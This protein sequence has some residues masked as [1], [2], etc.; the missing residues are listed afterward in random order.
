MGISLI[1]TIEARPASVTSTIDSDSDSREKPG[2]IGGFLRKMIGSK[3]RS[4]AQDLPAAKTSSPDV[5]EKS[6]TPAPHAQGADHA[7]TTITEPATVPTFRALSFKF[8]LEMQPHNKAIPPMR[9]AA[10]RLPTPAQNYLLATSTK[11]STNFATRAIEPTGES[12]ARAR[13]AGRA[14]AEW[15]IVV[16]ECGSFFDRRRKEGAPRDAEVETPVLGVEVFKKLG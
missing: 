15:A 5:K 4:K 9:L 11:S 7:T 12:I 16:G 1:D 2:S 3:S 13:Y 6:A 8:S 10:P 14:L